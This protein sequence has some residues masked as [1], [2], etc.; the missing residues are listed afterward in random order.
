[1][2]MIP[3]LHFIIQT[4]YEH[5][6]DWNAQQSHIYIIHETVM[7]QIHIR[8]YRIEKLLAE[9]WQKLLSYLSWDTASS[10]VAFFVTK[11]CS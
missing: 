3:N 8:C 7:I 10:V 2:E 1:M 6:V 9:K 4:Y 11:W 5:Y